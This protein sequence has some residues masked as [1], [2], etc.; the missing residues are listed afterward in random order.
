MGEKL[1]P[2]YLKRFKVVLPDGSEKK[3]PECGDS[4]EIIRP[5][6]TELYHVYCFD[7]RCSYT[8]MIRMPASCVEDNKYSVV[9]YLIHNPGDRD[10]YYFAY[11]PEFGSSACSGTGDTRIEALQNLDTVRENVILHYQETGREIPE[12][13]RMDDE[14]KEVTSYEWTWPDYF[15]KKGGVD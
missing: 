12:P 9:I 11:H 6:N 15:S 1:R 5:R 10:G 7:N 4:L 14:K 2:T 8:D 3:C 13:C